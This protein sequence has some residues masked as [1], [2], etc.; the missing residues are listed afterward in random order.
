MAIL[1]VDKFTVVQDALS[2]TGNNL[3]SQPDDGTD[4]WNVAGRAFDRY[5]PL[6]ISDDDWSFATR[7]EQL[8]SVL[9]DS[10]SQRYSRAFEK[11]SG[12]LHI[13]SVLVPRTGGYVSYPFTENAFVADAFE[14]VDGKIC[15]NRPDPLYAKFLRIPEPEDTHHHFLEALTLMVEA[16]CLRGLNED[17]DEAT[18]RFRQAEGMLASA[19]ARVAMQTPPRALRRSPLVQSRIRRRRA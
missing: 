10:P 19:K 3:A 18:L 13:V 15:T 2:S 1:P 4:E 12:S 6:L 7:I 14:I 8:A 17:Y 11:P 16:A 5:Y 9:P